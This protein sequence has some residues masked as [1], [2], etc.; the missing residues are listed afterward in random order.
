[1]ANKQ[2]PLCNREFSAQ[3]L[4]GHMWSMHGVKVGDRARL[5]DVNKRVIKLEDELAKAKLSD[6]TPTLSDF[7]RLK[8]EVEGLQHMH[9]LN[10]DTGLMEGKHKTGFKTS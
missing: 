6:N 9:R 7:N 10:S 5:E 3:G 4:G 1:M 2:C 8:T